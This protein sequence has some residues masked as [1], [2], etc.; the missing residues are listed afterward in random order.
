MCA[1]YG[2][3]SYGFGNEDGVRGI[4]YEAIEREGTRD[5]GTRFPYRKII[6]RLLAGCDKLKRNTRHE[7]KRWI[8]HLDNEPIRSHRTPR[9]NPSID[10]YSHRGPWLE[11]RYSCHDG[12]YIRHKTQPSLPVVIYDRRCLRVQIV[13]TTLFCPATNLGTIHTYSPRWYRAVWIVE[14]SARLVN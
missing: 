1:T 11:N 5:E 3:G 12:D 8:T 7:F 10:V 6:A 2:D 14:T 13:P 9:G 4:I